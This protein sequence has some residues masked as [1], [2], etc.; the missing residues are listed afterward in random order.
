M[1]LRLWGEAPCGYDNWGYGEM[2]SG[3]TTMQRQRRRL[4]ET[5]FVFV[6]L[7]AAG[8]V[9]AG[10]VS[11][12]GPLAMLSDDTSTDTETTATDTATDTT[13][14]DTTSSDTTS[15]DTTSTETT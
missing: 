2:G 12:A 5:F 15:T 11:G 1:R 9:T 10:V 7:F 13:S 6:A 3:P 8:L 4:L 14:S